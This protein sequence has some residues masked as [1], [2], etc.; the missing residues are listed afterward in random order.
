[1][2]T[3]DSIFP[4]EMSDEDR[5]AIDSI[6]D[7]FELAWKHGESPRV[8]DFLML[9]GKANEV[10]LRELLELDRNYRLL[11]K[12]LPTALTVRS[13]VHRGA[14]L[15]LTHGTFL[16]GRDPDAHLSLPRNKYCSWRHLE[17][18]YS[19]AAC[20]VRDLQTKNGT[21]ID[22]RSIAK[23]LPTSIAVGSVL[24]IGDAELL[25]E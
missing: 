14:R 7:R 25:A 17:I 13:G 18:R 22:G 11:Q 10:L 5:D 15:A 3:P 1:M 12:A 2:T 21:R 6:C 23:G 4:E 8:D 20:L 24:M 16:V 9:D 19:G